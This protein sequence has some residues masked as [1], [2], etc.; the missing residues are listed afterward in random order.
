MGILMGWLVQEGLPNM[1]GGW[2]A[3]GLDG[4]NL[5]MCLSSSWKVAQVCSHGGQESKRSLGSQMSQC[6]I[7]HIILVKASHKVSPD[8]RGTEINSTSWQEEL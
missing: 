5:V 8:S 1:Y 3:T 2:L 4:H 6:H 7:C